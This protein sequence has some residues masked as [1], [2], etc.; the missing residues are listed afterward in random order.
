VGISCGTVPERNPQHDPVPKTA[1]G[2][3][4]FFRDLANAVKRMPSQV[5]Y[6]C[7]VQFWAWIGWFPFL[8]YITTWI[9]GIYSEPFWEEDP[10]RKK[11]DINEI[12]EKATR[13]G[14]LALLIF[15]LTTFAASI[16]LPWMI[17][18]AYQPPTSAGLNRRDISAT[19][20]V[21]EDVNPVEAH[22]AS[23]SFSTR[24]AKAFNSL[25]L[26]L[27]V[28]GL[29]LRRT[30]LLSHIMFALCMFLTFFTRDTISAS[31]LVALIGIPWA[32]TNWAPFALI[33]AEVSKRDAIRRGLMRVKPT[34]ENARLM[35][36]EDEG[37]DQA[38]VVLGLHNV[39][40]AAPQVIASLGS[41]VIFKALQK[42]RGTPGDDSVG[43]VLRIGGICALVAAWC[44][45]WVKDGDED[46]AEE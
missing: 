18:P 22:S 32:V 24:L 16:V 4:A 7:L 27:R 28:P 44:S 5:K 15:A 40:I 42:E 38:G 17:I 31:I 46:V 25:I 11:G 20:P 1:D 36:G 21:G 30:W 23:P 34:A 33:S 6:V 35:S 26:R 9:G 3:F 10:N 45:R 19:T 41:S 12:W 14:S 13:V 43:W 29:T 39:A 2:V 37:A 8:F